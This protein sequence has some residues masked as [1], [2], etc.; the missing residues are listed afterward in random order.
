METYPSECYGWFFN[1]RPLKGKRKLQVRKQAAPALMKWAELA[2][3]TLSPDLEHSVGAGFPNGDDAFDSV[4]GL[5]GIIEVLSHRRQSGEPN[6]EGVR[7]LEGWIFGQN[8]QG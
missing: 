6:Q 3:V 2:N 7:K 1:G 8:S 4:V 5:F